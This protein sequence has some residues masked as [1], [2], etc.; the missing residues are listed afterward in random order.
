MPLLNLL[1]KKFKLNQIYTSKSQMK[2]LDMHRCTGAAQKGVGHVRHTGET[3]VQT[4]R[5]VRKSKS[6]KT[7]QDH[8]YKKPYHQIDCRALN[9]LTY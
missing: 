4:P 8:Q 1:K 9:L 3:P 6:R 7:V 2:N 5:Q